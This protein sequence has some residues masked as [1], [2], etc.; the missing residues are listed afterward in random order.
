MAVKNIV[1]AI[2]YR[3]IS[4]ATFTGSFIVLGAPLPQACFMIRIVNETDVDVAISYD[5]TTPHDY[6]PTET[7]VTLGFQ[8]NSQP[9]NYTALIPKGTQV[10]VRG[11]AGS[12]NIYLIGYFQSNA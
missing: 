7:Q 6:I 5:G 8:G 11:S 2:P 10:Y 3:T 9:N 12:G 1:R 4:A